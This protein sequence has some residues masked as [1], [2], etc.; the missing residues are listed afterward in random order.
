VIG[1]AD[2]TADFSI[3]RKVQGDHCLITFTHQH[4]IADAD[5]NKIVKIIALTSAGNVSPR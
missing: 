2:R 5:A 3:D 4:Y 1:D